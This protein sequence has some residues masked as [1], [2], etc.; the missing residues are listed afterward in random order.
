MFLTA[1]DYML[2]QNDEHNY[3]PFRRPPPLSQRNS[4]KLFGA[5]GLG[6]LLGLAY[7][8]YQYGYG[9]YMSMVTDQKTTEWRE[10]DAELKKINDTIKDLK[11]QI[12]QTRK[13]FDVEN[14][15]LTERQDLLT[16]IFDKKV[17][18][19]MKA[20]AIYDMS[21]LVNQ[22]QG[23]IVR[24]Q[25]ID[26]NLTISVRTS[27]DKQ[28]TKLLK[29]ISNVKP[30][31]VYTRSIALNDKNSTVKFYDSNISVEISDEK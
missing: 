22:N 3:S 20:N 17:K 7:P 19:P 26:R 29:D 25:D 24:I 1:Q 12:K 23:N 9:Y 28:M 27:S 15:I 6:L 18:Y 13:F 16:G 2:T 30:Y 21:N 14:K 10:K 4:G 5:L 11:E 8:A 31:A